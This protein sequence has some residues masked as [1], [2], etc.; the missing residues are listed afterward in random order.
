MNIFSEP[1]GSCREANLTSSGMVGW[2]GGKSASLSQ[3][4][5]C[6]SDNFP[7][8]L[9]SI[10]Y[11]PPFNLNQPDEVSYADGHGIVGSKSASLSQLNQCSSDNFP[12]GLQSIIYRPPFNLNQ[13]D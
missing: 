11:R 7:A 3:L 1:A 13:P 9:Q 10:I 5:Q 12:A 2:W 6:S 8:G 4:N